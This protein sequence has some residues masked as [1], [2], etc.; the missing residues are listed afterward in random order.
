M[1][2]PV[3]SETDAF[4]IT[5]GIAFL[6]GVSIAVG[7]LLSAVWGALV[8]ATVTLGVLLADL[9]A[10]DPQRPLPLRAAAHA[11]H[12]DAS[13]DDW[14]ILVVANEA[15][16]GEGV[17]GAILGRA[18]LRPEVMV[19]APVLVSRT[20]FVTTDVDAEMDEARARL[21][22]TLDWA[23]AHGLS[24]RGH[25]GD[26]MHPLLAVEDD[27]RRF[28]PDEVIVATHPAERAN[29]QEDS[30]IARLRSELDVPVT[31]VLVDRAHHRLEIVR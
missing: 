8:F 1:R 23:L 16:Q 31:Q 9:V 12:P 3:R 15:L 7:L 11:P 13:A 14:R 17:R 18:K 19:V 22:Q 5:Y 2:L 28:G 25:I 29:W 10:K 20:H 4:R 30:L 26:P 24:A 6:V 27:L 21:A